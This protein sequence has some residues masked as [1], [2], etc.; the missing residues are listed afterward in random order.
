MDPSCV[1]PQKTKKKY[2]F[3]LSQQA[4]GPSILRDDETCLCFSFLLSLG[5]GVEVRVDVL[6]SSKP[7]IWSRYM[8]YSDT[9]SHTRAF[10]QVVKTKRRN[11]G[12]LHCHL[13]Y[14]NKI[15]STRRE[16]CASYTPVKWIGVSSSTSKRCCLMRP[17]L[18]ARTSMPSERTTQRTLSA[19]GRQIP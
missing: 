3:F 13:Q 8:L 1:R 15:K 4:L 6:G 12:N 10:G 7:C 11:S 5:A 9:R 16:T 18:T 14:K 19:I 2:Y 17:P